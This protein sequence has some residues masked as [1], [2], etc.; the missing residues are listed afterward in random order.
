MVTSEI[1]SVPLGEK[2]KKGRPKKIQHC[3]S[4]S[5]PVSVRATEEDIGPEVDEE[6]FSPTVSSKA[7]EEDVDL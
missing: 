5:P 6:P 7:S 3:L 1:H 4:K 2:R